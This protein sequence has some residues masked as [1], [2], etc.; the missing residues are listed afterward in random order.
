MTSSSELAPSSAFL[1][2]EAVEEARLPAGVFNLVHG[3][4]PDVGEALVTHADVDMVSFTGSTGA[5][6]RIAAL[7]AQEVKRV[8][9]ELTW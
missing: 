9:L 7:A 1:L 6:R 4:G 2:A 8:A 3:R 5:G